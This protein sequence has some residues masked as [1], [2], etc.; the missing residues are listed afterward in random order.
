MSRDVVF[1]E[2]KSWD[3]SE[4]DES[5]T[6]GLESFTVTTSTFGT[7]GES[8][9]HGEAHS[10]PVSSSP[11]PSHS[12]STSTISNSQDGSESGSNLEGGTPGGNTPVSVRSVTTS[13]SSDGPRRYRPLSEIYNETEQIELED[14]EL[15][16]MGL[17]EPVNYT[18][19]VKGSEWK[20]A[21]EIEMDAVERNGT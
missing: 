20:K 21:M 8:Y 1:E 2:E 5:L 4:Q 11:T 9:H 12:G 7:V 14:E 18:Q 13:E 3:W 19:A 17:D 10:N 16:L 6:T 15:Y